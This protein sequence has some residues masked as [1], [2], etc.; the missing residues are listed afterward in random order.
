MKSY[1][2]FYIIH[3]QTCI[4]NCKSVVIGWIVKG[5]MYV[6][7]CDGAYV[8]FLRAFIASYTATPS[9]SCE[10]ASTT[11]KCV[12]RRRYV[13]SLSGAVLTMHVGG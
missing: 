7:P 8:V 4:L 5:L 6:F 9:A 2:Q 11:S 10:Y 13:A 12:G 1:S 3:V